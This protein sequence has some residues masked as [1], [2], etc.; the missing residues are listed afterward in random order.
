LLQIIDEDSIVDH[1]VY[2][3]C[4]TWMQITSTSLVV[5]KIRRNEA[6]VELVKA[7]PALIQFLVSIY[8]PVLIS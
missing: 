2:S 1:A 6:T 3:Y 5:G 8:P 4:A 7:S